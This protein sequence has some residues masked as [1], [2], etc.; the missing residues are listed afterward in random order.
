MC[1]YRT[2]S[3]RRRVHISHYRPACV[4]LKEWCGG[5]GGAG[6]DLVKLQRLFSNRYA[7]Q[8]KVSSLGFVYDLRRDKKVERERD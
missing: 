3:F 7:K 6:A 5:P 4:E 2:G 1:R 8:K